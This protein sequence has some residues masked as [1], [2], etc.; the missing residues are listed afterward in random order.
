VVPLYSSINFT[1]RG[2]GYL[3]TYGWNDAI[4]LLFSMNKVRLE[5]GSM[6]R[7][8]WRRAQ[9]FAVLNCRAYSDTITEFAAD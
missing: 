7:A 3:I 8:L 4:L 5:E 6:W 9:I 1:G 2:I